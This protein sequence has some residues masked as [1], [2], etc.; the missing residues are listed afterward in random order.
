MYSGGEG[1]YKLGAV[2]C[3]HFGRDREVSGAHGMVVQVVM[4][5]VVSFVAA[6]YYL[7]RVLLH[8]SPLDLGGRPSLWRL[9]QVSWP[10]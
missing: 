9:V 3:K 6:S 4:S 8:K 7:G 1:V 10:A 5:Y 2:F